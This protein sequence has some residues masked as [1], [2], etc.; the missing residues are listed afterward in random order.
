MSAG[1]KAGITIGAIIAFLILGVRTTALLLRRRQRA[2][3]RAWVAERSEDAGDGDGR[4]KR[5]GL[6]EDVDGGRELDRRGKSMELD[7]MG[8]GRADGKIDNRETNTEMQA[9][10]ETD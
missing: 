4:H 10:K 6:K 8:K 7:G 5:S 3:Q 9:E 2:Q 1:T